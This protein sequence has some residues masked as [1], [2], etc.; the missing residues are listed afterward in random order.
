[1]KRQPGRPPLEEHD[2][3]V[4]VCVTLPSKKYDDLYERARKE[5]TSVPEIIRRKLD[6]PAQP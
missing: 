3:S 1:M 4:K 2:E 5:R 6:D